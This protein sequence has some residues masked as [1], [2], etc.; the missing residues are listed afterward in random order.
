MDPVMDFSDA[1]DTVPPPA[2]APRRRGRPR[3]PETIQRDEQVL[4][5]LTAGG[6]QTR[7][8]LVEQLDGMKPSLVYLALWRLRREGRVE[9]AVDGGERHVWRVLA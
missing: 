4:K 1:P 6:P 7:E 2:T 8:R 5:L 3:S 9:R